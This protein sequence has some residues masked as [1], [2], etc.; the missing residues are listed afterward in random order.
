MRQDSEIE[1]AD[2]IWRH[3][4]TLAN[5]EFIN[6]NLQLSLKIYLNAFAQSKAVATQPL[7]DDL[8]VDQIDRVIAMRMISA[9]NLAENYKALSDDENM[10]ATLYEA[11]SWI[12]HLLETD[13][14]STSVK[15][16]CCCHQ[17]R[18]NIETKR[19]LK[20]SGLADQPL[21]EFSSCLQELLAPAVLNKSVH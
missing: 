4:S 18:L 7:L 12:S 1:S 17:K 19:M 13:G 20:E 16:T 15:Q 2:Q 9:L 11:Q 8:D 21:L 5:R 14:F 3:L 6:G 10:L